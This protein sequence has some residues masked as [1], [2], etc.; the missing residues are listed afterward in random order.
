MTI[1]AI[2][3]ATRVCG[4]ALIR[5]GVVV[6][7][8]VLDEKHVHAE[9]LMDLVGN[10]VRDDGGISAVEAVAVSI[11][12]GSFTGLRIGV[13]VA[14]GLVFGT[15]RVLVGVPT[16]GALIAR[17]RRE[18]AAVGP[19]DVLVAALQAR[20]GEYFVA[21]EGR[22]GVVI[23]RAPDIVEDLPSS[24]VILTGEIDH[25]PLAPGWRSVEPALRR[26]RA[27]SVGLLGEAMIREGRRDDA[28]TLEPAYALEFFLNEDTTE[29][30]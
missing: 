11:G 14:K 19:G 12:P 9:R 8:D 24:R 16:L 3:T 25:L 18:S 7:E 2:E 6:R 29:R 27:A 4:A 26:C 21:C 1:L 10:V 23:R 22:P 20:R 28:G 30:T 17:A 15:P 13:S 5:D